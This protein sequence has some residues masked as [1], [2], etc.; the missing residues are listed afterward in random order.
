MQLCFLIS[1]P[2]M[3]ESIKTVEKLGFI[4]MVLDWKMYK[5]TNGWR[6]MLVSFNDRRDIFKLLINAFQLIF[7]FFSEMDF[8]KIKILR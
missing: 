6:E 1:R 5:W 4:P 8:L 3:L 2:E 7:Q